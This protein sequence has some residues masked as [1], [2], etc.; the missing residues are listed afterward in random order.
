LVVGSLS[1][2]SN[3]PQT[4]QLS[5]LSTSHPLESM[6]EILIDWPHV[7]FSF[8]HFIFRLPSTDD[9]LHQGAK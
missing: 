3:T 9:R 1:L 2:R 6:K 8:M 4:S 7:Y 5:T